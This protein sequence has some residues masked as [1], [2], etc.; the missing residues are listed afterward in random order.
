MRKQPAR[1]IA[2]KMKNLS[3]TDI[4]KAHHRHII[5]NYHG[6]YD[7][8]SFELYIKAKYNTNQIRLIVTLLIR[9]LSRNLRFD[10]ELRVKMS[11]RI[12]L[13]GDILDAQNNVRKDL[14]CAYCP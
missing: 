11:E 8:I 9:H 14:G 13:E 2:Q 5:T 12:D 1:K 4:A 10:V 6:Y 3:S 7:F